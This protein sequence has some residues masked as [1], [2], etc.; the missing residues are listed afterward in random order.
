MA[1]NAGPGAV[2]DEKQAELLLKSYQEGFENGQASGRT[3]AW[4]ESVRNIKNS[5]TIADTNRAMNLVG[6]PEYERNKVMA[7]L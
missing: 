4:A 5:L 3:S 6:V 7:M 1:D 2:M